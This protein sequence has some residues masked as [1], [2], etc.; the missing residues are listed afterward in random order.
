MK[1]SPPLTW[2]S[3]VVFK[4]SNLSEFKPVVAEPGDELCRATPVVNGI[5]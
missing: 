5:D 2:R 4:M 3:G 1:D